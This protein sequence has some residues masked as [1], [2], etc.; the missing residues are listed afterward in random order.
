MVAERGH[1]DFHERIERQ[2]TQNFVE[3]GRTLHIEDADVRVLPG[4]PPQLQPL[5]LQLQFFR[6]L[7]LLRA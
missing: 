6:S 4:N 3:F 1:I 7:V 5:A 2:R